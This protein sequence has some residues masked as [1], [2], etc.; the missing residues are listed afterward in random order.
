MLFDTY[1]CQTREE[2]L[3]FHI[4]S[5]WQA[6]DFSAFH[7]LQKCQEWRQTKGEKYFIH[8]VNSEFRDTRY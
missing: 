4:N 2:R 8:P 1:D 3:R 6:A 7:S 5:S